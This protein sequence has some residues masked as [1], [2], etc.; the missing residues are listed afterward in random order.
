[1]VTAIVNQILVHGRDEKDKIAIIAND[2]KITYEQLSCL[3]RKAASFLKSKGVNKGDKVILEASPS[4]EFIGFYFATHLLNAVSVP[5]DIIFSENQFEEIRLLTDS[6]LIIT[7]QK[8]FSSTVLIEQDSLDDYEEIIECLVPIKSEADILFTSGT[9][10]KPKG[11]VLS[12]L[13]MRRGAEN[14]IEGSEMLKDTINLVGV[15]IHHS[16]GLGTVRAL[17]LNKATVVFV[18]GFSSL[19]LIKQTYDKYHC[20]ALS[21]VP[22]ALNIINEFC[23]GRLDLLFSSLR[24]FEFGSASISEK[25][26]HQLRTQFPHTKI[27]AS[28][29]STESPRTMYV[30]LSCYPYKINTIGRPLKNVSVSIIDDNFKEIESSKEKIG[31]VCF[32]GEMNSLRYWKNEEETNLVFR[33][34]FYFSNDLGYI[35]EDGFVCLVGRVNEILNIGGKKISTSKVE[36]IVNSCKGVK[37]SAC[38]GVKKENNILGEAPYVFVVLENHIQLT[39][40]VIQN[41]FI[42]SNNLYIKPEKVIFVQSLPLNRIGKVD[43]NLLKERLKNE[44]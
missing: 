13:S 22:S 12:H 23:K 34:K 32:K 43:K 39:E 15:P 18:N 10:G 21:I 28:Y 31:R 5:I 6:K 36:E 41:A 24:Y 16:F 9:T 11:V 8:K 17:L 37:E 38:I 19:K 29:G 2:R 33:D 35:D 1:M 25:M 4:I 42:Q 27:F 30:D 44:K 7:F 40:E 14:I 20:N 3:I 26:M